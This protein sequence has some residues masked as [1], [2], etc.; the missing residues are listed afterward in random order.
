MIVE[1]IVTTGLSHFSYFIGDAGM[2]AVIDP[3][4]DVEVYLNLAEREDLCIKWILETHR[5]EDFILGSRELADRTGAEVWHADGQLPY[6]FGKIIKATS[7]WMVGDLII[8]ALI[9]P[10]HTPGGASYLLLERDTTPWMVFTGDALFAGDVGRV[11]LLGMGRAE[12]MAGLLYQS[13]QKNL[14]TLGDGVI[15]CPAHGPESVCGA[16][17]SDRNQTTIGFERKANPFLQHDTREA[18]MAAAVRRLHRPP[19]FIRSERWN[20]EGPPLL[21]ERSPISPLTCDAFAG[22]LDNSRVLDVRSELSFASAHI[23]GSVYIS[24][25]N[26]QVHSGWFLD[27]DEQ[28][29]LVTDHLPAAEV[30]LRLL[31]VGLDNTGGFLKD[32]MNGWLQNGKETDSIPVISAAAFRRL[33]DKGP[34]PL[35]LDVREPSESPIAAKVG[36]HIPLSEILIRHGEL[37]RDTD[38]FILCGSGHRAMTAASLLKRTGMH[39]LKVILGGYRALDAINATAKLS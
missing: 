38:V 23:P 27:L 11:D 7:Q 4:R 17:I 19:Y 2:A 16:T 34:D 39:N 31:R 3:R 30:E 1:R 36:I 12:E 28:I 32:G 13:L 20:L 26:L 29:L 18:F 25:E 10:G 35:I 15:V 9:T 6:K 21:S 33:L 5:H 24:E 14:L 37:P 8:K 22:F